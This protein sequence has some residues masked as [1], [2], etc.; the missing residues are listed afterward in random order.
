M[1]KL[2][3]CTFVIA[4]ALYF[5]VP[6]SF[7]QSGQNYS[8]SDLEVWT[9]VG[10]KYKID[11]KWSVNYEE[12]LRL[13]DDASNVDIYFSELGFN[14][15]INKHVDFGLA[16]RFI[17]ENDD[18]G[19][20]QGYE[21]HFRWH[22]DVTYEHEVNKFDLSYRILYHSKD[23]LGVPSNVVD[24]QKNTVRF[25]FGADYKFKNWKLDPEFSSEIFNRVRPSDGFEKIR[26]TLGTTYKTKNMGDFSAF[27]R[28]EKELT[29][30]SP[31]TTNIAGLKYRYTIKRKKNA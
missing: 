3:K 23:E 16:G 14:Y 22:A 6:E 8:D 7:A 5:T 24:M 10:L 15:K 28:L 21:N 27:Y 20:I 4:L 19:K 11:K 18:K 25:K 12:Q 17:R 2:L 29:D 13:R 9:S 26:F 1:H 30:Q 31:K